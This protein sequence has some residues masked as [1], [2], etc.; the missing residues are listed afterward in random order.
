[1]L[2]FAVLVDAVL[3]LQRERGIKDAKRKRHVQEAKR[4][5]WREDTA[6]PFS[7]RNI[8][9]ALGLDA[10]YLRRGLRQ[11]Q[12]QGH[13]GGLTGRPRPA[14]ARRPYHCAR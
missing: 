10:D 11:W 1:M 12:S 5:I 6:W 7:F 13:P 9:D 4:W 2:R 14:A 8:C 3:L